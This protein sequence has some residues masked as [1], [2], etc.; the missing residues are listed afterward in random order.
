MVVHTDCTTT[1]RYF[2]CLQKEAGELVP[3]N[4]P[5]SIGVDF[6]EEQPEILI[7]Q[8]LGI[9]QDT[10]EGL[11]KG[12]VQGWGGGIKARFSTRTRWLADVSNRHNSD[13]TKHQTNT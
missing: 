11:S 9:G 7:G 13:H 4:V 12:N 1:L 5:T 10:T 2:S 8:F 3:V 6:H